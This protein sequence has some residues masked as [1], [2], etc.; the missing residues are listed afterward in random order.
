MRKKPRAGEWLLD[1]ITD[2]AANGLTDVVSLLED[3]E[4]RE[5]ELTGEAELVRHAGMEFE[6][7]PI[8]HRG[9]PSSVESAQ[10][11]WQMVAGGRFELYSNYVLQIQAVAVSVASSQ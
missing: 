8:A 5:L 1:E 6:S 11:L 3:C 9:I 2:W 10:D 4:V 7:F